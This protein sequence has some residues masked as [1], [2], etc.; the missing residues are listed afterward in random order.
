MVC[1]Y[2]EF[3][4]N[5]PLNQI[6]KTTADYL[7]KSK[8]VGDFTKK[9]LKKLMLFFNNVST[10][11]ISTINWKNLIFN[12]NNNSY[13]SIMILCELILKGLIASSEK[14][15]KQFKEFLDE[16]ALNSI[17]ESLLESTIRKKV[18]LHLKENLD[19]RTTKIVL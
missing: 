1:E 8:K 18:Y 17:Y 9:E 5:N 3:S 6:I 10:I 4:V 15:E 12:R 14:G 13:K 2:D 11:D 7:I 16:T 19:Y